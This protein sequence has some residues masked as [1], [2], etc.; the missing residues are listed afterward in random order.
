[1]GFWKMDY[2]K[3]ME[4]PDIKFTAQCIPT[5]GESG[6]VCFDRTGVP[7]QIAAIFG[8]TRCDG[9][10][11]SEPCAPCRKWASAMA[12]SFLLDNNDYSNP[13]AAAWEL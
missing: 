10:D 12:V 8:G 3:M 6:R 4:D 1:M 9:Q 11:D 2:E 13:T 5:P 7:V